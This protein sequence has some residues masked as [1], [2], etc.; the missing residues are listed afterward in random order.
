MQQGKDTIILVQAADA[1][2]GSDGLMIAHLTE[3]S[4][5]V[6]ND[7]IDES[8]KFGRIVGYG[9][10]S[11]AF[12][13]SAYGESG[14]PGQD[15]TLNAI[16]NKKQLKLWEV[17]INLNKTGKHDAVFGYTVVESHE[18]ASAQDGFVEIS[19]TAQVIGQTVKGE[20]DPLPP[21]LID[22]AKY[23]FEAP[24]ETIGEFPNQK[25]TAP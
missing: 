17:N 9:Q 24:G 5:S 6:E 25:S 14:D 8:T 4:H 21:E 19:V 11:E 23:G 20:I 12:E 22:F 16:M 18:K 13:F 1:A 10:T 15:A 3:N 2:L 7:L